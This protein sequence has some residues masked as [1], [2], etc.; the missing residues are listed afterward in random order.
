VEVVRRRFGPHVARAHVQRDRGIEEGRRAQEETKRAGA[1]RMSLDRREQ[2]ASDTATA[3]P[4]RH[5][6]TADI[7]TVVSPDRG[8][9]SDDGAVDLDDPGRALA[10]APTDLVGAGRGRVEG[11]AR[12]ERR[13]LRERL[14]Q[15]RGDR[16]RI[17]RRRT[18][19]Q[20]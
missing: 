14:A 6:R 10:E 15:E 20:R 13:E 8:D 7:D 17:T 12:V 18:A 5:R 1:A 2:A 11:G 4:R 16:R 3:V 19:C 9:R